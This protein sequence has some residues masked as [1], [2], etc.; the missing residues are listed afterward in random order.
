MN[1][2]PWTSI[3]FLVIALLPA[4]APAQNLGTQ[5][6]SPGARNIRVIYYDNNFLFMAR[7]YGSR[8]VTPSLVS[9]SILKLMVVGCRFFK[10]RQ[11]TVSLGNRGQMTPRKI[12]GS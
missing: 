7:D 4:E 5:A 6:A 12:S 3:L 10:S 8:E 11:K 9:L 2:T 1:N